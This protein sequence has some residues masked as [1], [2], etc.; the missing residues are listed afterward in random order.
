ML[1]PVLVLDEAGGARRVRGVRGWPTLACEGGSFRFR[2][3]GIDVP[4]PHLIPETA[5][6]DACLG[7]RPED[8]TFGSGSIEGVVQLVEHTGHEDIVV[9]QIGGDMRLT[10]RAP[11]PSLWRP[12]QN[13]RCSVDSLRAH[14]FAAGPFGARLNIA[15][16]HAETPR[17]R[18]VV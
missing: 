5:S 2:A 10:G 3:P 6:G 1:V 17:I 13:V 11:A 16:S 4:A 9:V 12:G 14:V 7:V 15:A 18:D 8:V